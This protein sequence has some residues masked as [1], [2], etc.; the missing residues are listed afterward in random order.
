MRACVPAKPLQSC[1][2]VCNPMD[3]NRPCFSVHGIFQAEILEYRNPCPPP[4]DSPNPGIESASL[5][6]LAFQTDSLLLSH[7]EVQK[8]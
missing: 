8:L 2:T 4:V 3:C 6:V 7:R 5:E 1:P